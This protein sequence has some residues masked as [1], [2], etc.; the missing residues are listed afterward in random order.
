MSM[1]KLKIAAYLSLLLLL[2]GCWDNLELINRAFVM[3]VALDETEKGKVQLTTQAYNPSRGVQG[4]GG[5]G[6]G[7]QNYINIRTTEDSVN[8]AV[9]D[10][11]RHIGRKAQWGHLYVI[12]ISEEFARNQG[13]EEV[14]A[15]FF[16]D[17]EPRLT[18]SVVI[19]KGK[20]ADFLEMEPLMEITTGQ[21]LS[22]N[23]EMSHKYSQKTIDS[24]LLKLAIQTRNQ[25]GNGLLP[26]FHKIE[27]ASETSPT[28]AG[29]TLLKKGKM[30]G[31][32]PTEKAERLLL[33]RDEYQG[34]MIQL[35]CKNDP[36]TIEVIEIVSAETSLKPIIKDDSLTVKVSSEI[37]AVLQQLTC[38][39]TDSP[40]AEKELEKRLEQYIEKELEKTINVLQEKQFDAMDLGDK[41]YAKNPSVWKRWKKDWD[42]RFADSEF[43]FDVQIR[44]TSSGTSSGKPWF[45][46]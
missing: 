26:Y 14:L 4:E 23:E 45:S 20:A 34:G 29:I 21:Q 25:V 35:P 37:E 28:V 40:E 38:S 10:I 6:Q 7:S 42:Q 18:A 9:R 31:N 33:I 13:L 11:P 30:V 19:T 39:K 46:E 15:F 3:G 32:L 22:E 17:H 36:S 41:V 5:G 44:I 43:E 2:T 1:N 8:E 24:N 16:R 27:H 12:V